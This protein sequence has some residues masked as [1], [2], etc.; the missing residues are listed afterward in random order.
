MENKIKVT[1]KHRLTGLTNT[2]E[3]LYLFNIIWSNLQYDA[4]VDEYEI[5]W[6]E[7]K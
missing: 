6:E 1:V 4:E 7:K 3:D 5:I 2:F